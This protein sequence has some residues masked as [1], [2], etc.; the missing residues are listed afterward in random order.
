M[1]FQSKNLLLAHLLLVN[2]YERNPFVIVKSLNG[3][4]SVPLILK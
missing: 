2:K 3:I 1:N 4:Y